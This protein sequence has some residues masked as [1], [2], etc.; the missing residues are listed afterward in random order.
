V[1]LETG[2]LANLIYLRN[3]C[4]RLLLQIRAILSDKEI[5]FDDW[6]YLGAPL[7]KS[8]LPQAERDVAWVGLSGLA[9]FY[10]KQKVLLALRS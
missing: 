2:L 1:H 6:L 8:L 4:S 9:L 7:R 5:A 3:S 10:K